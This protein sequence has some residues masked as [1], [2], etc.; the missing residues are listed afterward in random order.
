M[1]LKCTCNE[2]TKL[3][4][5]ANHNHHTECTYYS[6]KPAEFYVSERL[7]SCH[8]YLNSVVFVK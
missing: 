2:N 6:N 5:I 1:W 7:E 4:S 8:V 3:P